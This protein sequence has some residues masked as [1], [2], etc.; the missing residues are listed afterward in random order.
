MQALT[1]RKNLAKVEQFIVFFEFEA[2]MDKKLVYESGLLREGE[3]E[4]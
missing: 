4:G 1:K 3:R 2:E